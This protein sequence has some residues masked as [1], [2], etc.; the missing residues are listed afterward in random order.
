MFGA[1]NI[2]EKGKGVN[3][4]YVYAW[5]QQTRIFWVGKKESTLT[6]NLVK[7]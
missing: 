4:A 5:D 3:I 6:Y 7:I 2:V 1:I